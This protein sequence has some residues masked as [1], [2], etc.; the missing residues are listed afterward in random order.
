M[1]PAY[2]G[3]RPDAAA[4][5]GF[6]HPPR[7]VGTVV[8]AHTVLFQDGRYSRGREFAGR[9]AEVVFVAGYDPPCATPHRRHDQEAAAGVGP[10]DRAARRTVSVSSSAHLFSDILWDDIHFERTPTTLLAYAQSKTAN[11]LFAVVVTQHWSREG[12]TANAVHPGSSRTPV[13]NDT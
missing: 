13:C 4:G 12:I 5:Q 6:G 10:D 7:A 9:N 1:I 2:G 8:A 3:V 11:T